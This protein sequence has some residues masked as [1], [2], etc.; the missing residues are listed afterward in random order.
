V[1]RILSTPIRE[2]RWNHSVAGFERFGGTACGTGCGFGAT[3]VKT[4]TRAGAAPQ[5]LGLTV[6][7][8]R[9]PHGF[10]TSSKLSIQTATCGFR[11]LSLESLNFIESKVADFATTPDHV[12]RTRRAS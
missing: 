1:F 3:T 10:V 7:A 12:F 4:T 8:S 6:N 11:P 9:L 5:D 2:P